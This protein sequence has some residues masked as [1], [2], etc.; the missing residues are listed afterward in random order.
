MQGIL[1]IAKGGEIW[2]GRL[3]GATDG[4]RERG[5]VLCLSAVGK[6]VGYA[7]YRGVR[8]MVGRRTV[9]MPRYGCAVIRLE[10]KKE[11]RRC[12]FS[13]NGEPQG[14]VYK[15]KVCGNM[16]VFPHGG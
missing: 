2:S 3:E 16:P 6:V 15:N 7:K 11:D 14:F 1:L 12:S 4:E 9:R 10:P 8:I 5:C 13:T